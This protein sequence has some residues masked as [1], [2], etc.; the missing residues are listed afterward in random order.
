MY[1]MPNFYKA[2]Q[3]YPD[4]KIEN[5][6]ETIFTEL[7]KLLKESKLPKGSTIAITAGSRGINQIADIFKYL[8][9]KLKNEDYCP[10]IFSAKGSHGGGEAGG[11]KE[12][13]ESLGITEEYVGT[14]ISCSSEVVHIGETTEFLPGLP[15]YTAK[16]AIDADTILIVNRIK[17][18]TNFSGEFESGIMKMMS[19]GM[20]RATGAAMVHKLGTE[21]LLGAIKAIG[22]TVLTKLP[23]L[24]AIA[25]VENAYEHTAIIEGIPADKIMIREPEL[26]K[27]AKALMPSIPFKELD[28]L[29]VQ[30]IGKNFSGTGM[31]TNIIGRIRINGIPEPEDFRIKYIGALDLSEESHGNATGVGLADFTT[32]R[33]FEKIDYRKTYTNVLTSGNVMRVAI[34]MITENDKDLLYTFKKALKIEDVSALKILILKNTLHVNEFWI[35]EGL[36]SYSKEIT[37]LDIESGPS[38]LSFDEYQNIIL[39]D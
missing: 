15:V 4:N 32:K 10:F 6:K 30:E 13:L 26:L 21:N 27:S 20:G 16:E 17:P 2:K 37:H 24:G 25:I 5:C 8:V 29:V 31:D 38:P 12:L 28:L 34:P 36:L 9:E 33:L 3:M 22:K 39:N 7:D 14:K 35:S 1:E 19:V 18:H 23:V 11:Q